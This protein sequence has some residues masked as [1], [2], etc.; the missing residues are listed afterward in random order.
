MTS[1]QVVH[2][3]ALL[4]KLAG[5]EAFWTGDSSGRAKNRLYGR[6]D[7]VQI[8]GQNI[9][10]CAVSP[11]TLKTRHLPVVTEHLG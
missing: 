10:R 6:S 7:A 9:A 8:A 2:D 4:S 3:G 11:S 5:N 1:E